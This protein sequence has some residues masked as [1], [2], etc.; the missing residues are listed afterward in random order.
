MDGFWNIVL[1][2]I[3]IVAG[4]FVLYQ[5][6]KII[7]GGSKI[8]MEV[9]AYTLNNFGGS[10]HAPHHRLRYRQVASPASKEKID[11]SKAFYFERSARKYLGRSYWVYFN[12]KYPKYV[13]NPKFHMAEYLALF[14]VLLGLLPIIAK[15][16]Q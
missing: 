11:E 1:S 16:A 8:E 15:Y 5:K 3:L 9:N 14:F 13:V 12:K 6:Y 4:L 2:V 10:V 7:I